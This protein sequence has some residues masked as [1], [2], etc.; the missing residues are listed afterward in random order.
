MDIDFDRYPQTNNPS[1]GDRGRSL[2]FIELV[3]EM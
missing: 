1:E 2:Y 3:C